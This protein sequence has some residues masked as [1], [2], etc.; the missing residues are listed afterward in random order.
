MNSRKLYTIMGILGCTGLLAGQAMAVDSA[1]KVINLN[2]SNDGVPARTGP[3]ARNKV[4]KVVTNKERKKQDKAF[5]AS[6]AS[7]DSLLDYL[8]RNYPPTTQKAEVEKVEA[9]IIEDTQSKVSAPAA[10]PAG[11][12]IINVTADQKSEARS[13]K[14]EKDALASELQPLILPSTLN[15]E[16]SSIK[17]GQQDAMADTK[18]TAAKPGEVLIISRSAEPKELVIEKPELEEEVPEKLMPVQ[19]V[20]K[21][22][23]VKLIKPEAHSRKSAGL[24]VPPELKAIP[25]DIPPQKAKTA[26]VPVVKQAREEVPPAV[27]TTPPPLEDSLK[28]AV[29]TPDAITNVRKP[30]T[31]VINAVDDS[32]PV[33]SLDMEVPDS[34]IPDKNTDLAVDILK[35]KL[36]MVEPNLPSTQRDS[37]HTDY[38]ANSR[39]PLALGVKAIGGQPDQNPEA[40]SLKP[41]KNKLVTKS[42]LPAL[43]EAAKVVTGSIIPSQ[44]TSDSAVAEPPALDTAPVQPKIIALEKRETKEAAK[45]VPVA[46]VAAVVPA[47]PP[48]VLPVAPPVAEPTA[49]AMPE[50]AAAEIKTPTPPQ[51]ESTIPDEREVTRKLNITQNLQPVAP[52][53]ERIAQ[54]KPGEAVESRF[55]IGDVDKPAINEPLVLRSA[56]TSGVEGQEPQDNITG[57]KKRQ[58]KLYY[59]TEVSNL[60][61]QTAYHRWYLGDKLLADKRLEIGS[62]KWR[63]WSSIRVPPST[64]PLRLEVVDSDFKIIA[65]E[66]FSAN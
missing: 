42:P 22:D 13:Q 23:E 18:K 50:V 25:Q 1:E 52:V 46:A 14:S 39:L 36:L 34:V 30:K 43:A 58:G 9:H 4:V 55:T 7:V 44:Q 60:S 38:S 37:N 57:G 51:V 63:A 19:A 24:R 49:R 2:G 16:A 6:P 20:Q 65:T 29:N 31:F 28:I 35:P 8:G 66:K 17:T 11:H 32:V 12:K 3:S 61:G 54:V 5:E 59:F 21:A 41:E 56:L 47:P 40:R 27:A 62:G 45:P 10:M 64:E 48:L 15:G 53:I 33:K 26:A